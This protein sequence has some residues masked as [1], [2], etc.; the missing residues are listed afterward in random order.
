[1]SLRLFAYLSADL[2]NIGRQA[3]EFEDLGFDGVTAAEV[4][5]EP[6]LDLLLAAEHTT[7]LRLMTGIA[8]AFART[9]MLVATSAHELNAFSQGRFLLGL[10]S[11]VEAHITRR[12]SMPWSKPAAR[13]AE[14]VQA[15]HA[16]FGA[17]YEDQKLSFS[18]EF[19]THTLMSPRFT[20]R[21]TAY[22]SCP[23]YIAA[24]GPLMTRAA[25]LVA[26]GVIL[27]SF[28][29]EKYLRNQTLP[30]VAAGLAAT[31]GGSKAF[32]LCLAP[33]IVTGNSAAELQAARKSVVDQIAFYASTPAY[34]AVLEEHGWNDLQ[35]R[36]HKMT[37]ENRWS[38]MGDLITDEMLQ[39]F[40]IVGRPDEV[41]AQIYSR[42][43]SAVHDIIINVEGASPELL[44]RI[45]ADIKKADEQAVHPAS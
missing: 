37:R 40:A 41:G 5:R 32:R 45:G 43:G 26:D 9:P 19:Y 17:W 7:R 4:A 29:T 11:Q 34:R 25:A 15:L 44:A 21:N 33:F 13:M 2:S 39:S 22:G 1:M 20:P 30:N 35:P 38:E 18:G 16:I 12:Y 23:I 36:L 28:T 6:F 3:R 8:V 24:V 10:G 31:S 14:F 42:Y 27:H